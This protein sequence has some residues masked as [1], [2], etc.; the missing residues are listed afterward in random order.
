M[1][2][3]KHSAM[4]GTL[5]DPSDMTVQ[6]FI[7]MWL[8]SSVK[9]SVSDATHFTYE[10]NMRSHVYKTIGHHPIQKLTPVH[11]QKMLGGM[12]DQRVKVAADETPPDSSGN[13]KMQILIVLN[14]AMEKA[15]DLNVI[16]KNPCSRVEA[17][18]RVHKEMN[19]L[20]LEE[21]QLVRETSEKLLPKTHLFFML[22]MFGGFRS[23]EIR[24]LR[25]PDISFEAS[26]VA[27]N[28]TISVTKQGEIEKTVKTAKA[29]RF[30]N[31]PAWLMEEL[32]K[33][34][35]ER[36]KTEEGSRALLF[37]GTS[38]GFIPRNLLLR[39]FHRLLELCGLMRRRVHDLRHTHATLLLLSGIH[40]K[41]VQE[42]LGHATIA[43]TLDLYSHVLPTMQ[44]HAVEKLDEIF[45]KKPVGNSNGNTSLKIA[46]KKPKSKRFA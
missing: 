1:T 42:R 11:I 39:R 46:E 7:E 36:M 15:V 23:S 20:N 28:R 24:A 34:A 35:R 19:P 21:S 22:A 8:T 6:Q 18:K 4:E 30:V 44:A 27:I 29:R 12:V 32:K 5:V 45:A 17:P 2:K 40:P 16:A 38:G 25:I 14:K 33:R 31:L 43:I 10:V 13:T 3:L 37:V 41:V 9:G 26:G